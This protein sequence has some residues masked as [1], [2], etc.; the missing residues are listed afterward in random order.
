MES[1]VG[2]EAPP[3]FQLDESVPPDCAPDDISLSVSF[4]GFRDEDLDWQEYNLHGFR[5]GLQFKFD[6]DLFEWLQ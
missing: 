2:A 4:T 1:C 6:E 5:V 3:G